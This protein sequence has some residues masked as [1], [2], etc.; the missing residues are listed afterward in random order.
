[1][2]L[3]NARAR[4]EERESGARAGAAERIPICARG[5]SNAQAQRFSFLYIV[6]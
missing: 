3:V 2:W 5:S 6:D 4:V 1:M